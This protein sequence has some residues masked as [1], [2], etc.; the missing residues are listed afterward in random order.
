MPNIAAPDV[1]PHLLEHTYPRIV[2]SIAEAW[3]SPNDAQALFKRLL[4]D[5]RGRRQGFPPEVGREIMRLCVF[6]TDW[7]AQVEATANVWTDDRV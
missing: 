1:Y 7:Q 4:I 2:Q 3:P 6:Y 5:D